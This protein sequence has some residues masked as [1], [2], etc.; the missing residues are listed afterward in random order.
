MKASSGGV[1]SDE[2]YPRYLLDRIKQLEVANIRLKES[3]ERIEREGQYYDDMRSRYE[4]ELRKLRTE[5]EKLRAPPLIIGTVVEVL[6]DK[7]MIVRSSTGPRFVV[8]YSHFID[9]KEVFAG[10]QVGLNQQ[11]LAVVSVLSSAKDPSVYGMEVIESPEADYEMIG[12]LDEQIEEIT[13]I[14][15]LPLT[16]PERFA[17]I[18]VVPPK[19]VLLVGEPGTGKTMLAKAVANRTS[20]TFIRVVGSELVQKYIGEGARMVRELFEL[21]K[22]KTPSIL[23]IDEIDAIA[24]RRIEDGT[25]GE[26]EVQR[27]MMQL[28]AEVDGFDQRG[29]VRIIGATNRPDILDPALLRPGRF[30]RIIHVPVPDNEGRKTIFKIHTAAMKVR[31]DV[32]LEILAKL[33]EDA[34]GAEIKAISI[35]A[36]MFAARNK[37]KAIGMEDFEQAIKKVKESKQWDYLNT[38]EAG[39]MFA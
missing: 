20:A 8:N 33:T 3:L 25:S 32:D 22:E 12:G 28:L 19:G 15:E 35:E 5:L 39:V 24:A 21:A 1:S 9:Q 11:S 29:E 27:T 10:A 38:K 2:D 14:V 18:G 7:K 4:G 26:R 34:T 30:D 13:E 17:R 36:G 31:K 37:K 23:F 16:N 6:D